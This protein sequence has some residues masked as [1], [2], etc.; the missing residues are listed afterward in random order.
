MENNKENISFIL[1][2]T[3]LNM[4]MSVIINMRIIY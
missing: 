2:V 3:Q 4:V 1:Q